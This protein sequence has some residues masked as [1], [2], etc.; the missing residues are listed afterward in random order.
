MTNLIFF[1]CTWYSW[2]WLKHISQWLEGKRWL[3]FYHG[4]L[5]VVR[6]L[7]PEVTS[8]TTGVCHYIHKITAQEIKI[9]F[10]LNIQI[11]YMYLYLK[12]FKK[13]LKIRNEIR[14]EI[15]DIFFTHCDNYHENTL[16]KPH[17]KPQLEN[18]NKD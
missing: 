16:V 5:R 13:N 12:S 8:N 18:I 9:C 2:T 17:S 1:R 15:T 11:F 14:S 3:L 7:S 6:G 10:W 4:F